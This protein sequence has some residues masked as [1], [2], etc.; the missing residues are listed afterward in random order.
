MVLNLNNGHVLFRKKVSR[1]AC[2][3]HFT[4]CPSLLWGEVSQLHC[5]QTAHVKGTQP[6][7]QKKLKQLQRNFLLSEISW[8]MPHPGP[9]V[10]PDAA[11]TEGW[12]VCNT[13]GGFTGD[14][15]R[16]PQVTGLFPGARKWGLCHWL[17]T[18]AGLGT[19]PMCA[20]SQIEKRA[21]SQLDWSS[22]LSG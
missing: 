10:P 4:P 9:L 2:I 18:C 20:E 8:D 1:N 16:M 7:L 5:Q 15:P 3:A 17:P 14:L 13:C 11:V 21:F 19:I 12:E 22:F 6:M